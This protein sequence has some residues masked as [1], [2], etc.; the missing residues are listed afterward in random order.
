MK[1]NHAGS[2]RRIRRRLTTA[3]VGGGFVLWAWL[4]A[5]LFMFVDPV[6]DQPVSAD[7]VVVLAPPISTGRLDYAE[8][9]MSS[10]YSATLVISAP[11]GGSGK[12][13][14]EVCR[15]DQPYRVICFSPNPATTQGEARAI[16]RLSEEH[17]WHSI[18]V[19]TDTF[20]V[21]RARIIIGRCYSHDLN[22]VAYNR[23][24]SLMSW[25]YRFVYESA[26]FV[27]VAGDSGC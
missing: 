6:V 27:K 17:G 18:T 24:R 2:P 8:S 21:T 26:A 22:I 19:V 15:A 14:A 9:L 1:E 7:A 20:H 13:P 12:A 4:V 10:G 25:A 23:D 3:L 11:D 16:Q 5:G